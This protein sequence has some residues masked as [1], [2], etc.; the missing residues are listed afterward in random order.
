MTWY[1]YNSYYCTQKCIPWSVNGFIHRPTCFLFEWRDNVS[2]S[3][4]AC[5]SYKTGFDFVCSFVLYGCTHSCSKITQVDVFVSSDFPHFSPF[6]LFHLSYF[7]CFA[8]R[9]SPDSPSYLSYFPCFR[10]YTS[11]YH[12]YVKLTHSVLLYITSTDSL[13][14]HTNYTLHI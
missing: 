5:I 14:S 13:V 11:S 12:R 1:I 10:Y 3:L 7:L 4:H 2:V 9:I 8:F 6:P